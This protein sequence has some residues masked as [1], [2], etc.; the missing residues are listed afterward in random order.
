VAKEK[1][2]FYTLGN[3]FWG[4][5]LL[6]TV[7]AIGSGPTVYVEIL[8]LCIISMVGLGFLFPKYIPKKLFTVSEVSLWLIM[9][10][11]A[12]LSSDIILIALSIII[13]MLIAMVFAQVYFRRR[14]TSQNPTM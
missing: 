2:L 11:T 12:I 6:L 9:L 3:I 4:G 8:R 13:F 7:F 14:A 5:I 1:S 10:T